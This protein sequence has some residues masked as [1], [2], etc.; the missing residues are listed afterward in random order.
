MLN[1]STVQELGLNLRGRL[2]LP[3]DAEYDEARKIWNVMIDRRPAVIVRCAGAEDVVR[4]VRFARENNLLVAV[5]GGGHNVAG[6]AVC[7]GGLMIDLS[8][9]KAIRIDPV[10]QT[11]QAQPGLTL[12]EF[13][14][15]TQAFGLATTLGTVSVTGIAGLTL[16]GGIGWL[17]GKYGLACDNLLSVDI[18]TADGELRTASATENEDLFWGVR[19]GG[20][21]F[22]VVTRFEYRLH[23]VGPVLG[24]MLIYPFSKARE[25]L[26]FYWDFTSQ[27]PDELT[28]DAGILTAPDGNPVAAIAICYCGPL[29]QGEKLVEPLRKFGPPMADLIGPKSY[30]EIQKEIFDA[31]FP[32][33]HQNYWKGGFAQ[34]LSDPVIEAMVEYAATRPSPASFVAVEHFHGAA[35]RVPVS[36][37]AFPHRR[38][39]Y[40]L[41]ICSIWP[42]P[43]ESEKNI[44]WTRRFWG[45]MQP[46]MAGSVYVNY[47]SE[48]GEDR[49]RAAYGPN[50]ERLVALKSKYDPTNFFRM[51]QNIQPTVGET[52]SARAGTP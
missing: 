26:R 27:V 29:D 31:A 40:S 4:A 36:E 18:V 14:R 39:Q 8:P 20:G 1:D 28:M 42:D 35:A 23:R 37:T 43:A 21:N 12:G 7:D 2:L 30:L 15:E 9:L 22:G 41:L 13:D 24:G 16:G 38:E 34:A 45:A 52:S 44:E 17:M 46:F 47:L 5:R 48:E 51:N 33:N 32:P 10:R 3:A 49:V 25:V 50:Y 19:G 11:A 6:N